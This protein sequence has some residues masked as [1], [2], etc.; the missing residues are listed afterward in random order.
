MAAKLTRLTHEVAIQLH[1]KPESCTVCSSRSTRP[2]LELLDTPSYIT[3]DTICNIYN[4]ELRVAVCL[5]LKV[6]L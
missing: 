3:N 1:L 5:M 6:P 4:N 2:I